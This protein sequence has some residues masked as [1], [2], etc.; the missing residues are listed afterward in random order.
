LSDTLL[1]GYNLSSVLEQGTTGFQVHENSEPIRVPEKGNPLG[2]WVLGFS[3]DRTPKKR[4][5]HEF[6]VLGNPE[7]TVKSEFLRTRNPA[8]R[9][10]G[11]LVWKKI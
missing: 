11:D 7:P 4:K 5:W 9:S 6:R 1:S 8:I 2:F 3:N 10:S